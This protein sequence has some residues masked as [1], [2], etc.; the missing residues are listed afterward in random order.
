MVTQVEYLIIHPWNIAIDNSDCLYVTE[1]VNKLI[2]KF[3]ADGEFLEFLGLFSEAV[4]NKNTQYIPD[5]KVYGANMG[6]TWAL[7][8]PGGP[9][10]GPINLAIRDVM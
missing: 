1:A 6:P 2:Q 7:S 8:V 3:T 9:H 10:V 5:S 4:N